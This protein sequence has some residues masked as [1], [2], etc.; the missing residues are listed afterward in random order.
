MKRR[1]GRPG[2]PV[3]TP[4]ADAEPTARPDRER[5]PE[6][7]VPHWWGTE[8][9]GNFCPGVVFDDEEKAR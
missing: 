3:R 5:D 2:E 8:E 4:E 9:D 1:S 6:E 7:R